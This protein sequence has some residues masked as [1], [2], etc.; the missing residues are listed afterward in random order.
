MQA[1]A[2]GGA[3]AV[4][5]L[6]EPTRFGG[7]LEH[8]AQAAAVLAPLNVPVMRKD[9]LVD[10]YQVMEGARGRRRRRARD[11]AHARSQSHH[12]A[13]RLRGD[14][15]DV[16]AARSVRCARSASRA[17]KCWRRAR[18]TD[19]QILVGLNCRDL[20]TLTIDLPRLEELADHLPPGFAHV[21]ESG[22]TSLED[23]KTV[24]DIGYRVALV[25]TT[26]MNSPD[27]RKLLGEM[28]AAGR[29][30]AMAVRTQNHDCSTDE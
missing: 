27:P 5:V 21:A 17:A 20:E 29:E 15:E 10:P 4:S 2:Q 25:G 8:L 7:A 16:R 28:L 18:G 24:V 13:A 3:C 14:A 19:E 9:F 1:Y 23:V 12:G 6:T 26:L 30:R 11:R 22:V